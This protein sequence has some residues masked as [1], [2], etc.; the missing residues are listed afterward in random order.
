MI[1]SVQI[2]QILPHRYPFLLVDRILE[3]D[4][5]KHV[6]GLK[7]VTINEPFFQGHFPGKPIVPGVI[8]L[9]IMSQIGGFV[10]LP[11]EN[12]PPQY[13]AG[14]VVGF[15]RVRFRRF[16]V[17]GDTL[18]VEAELLGRLQSL[19]KVRATAFVKD[20]VVAKAEISYNLE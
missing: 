1:E 6:R 2:A 4:P 5:G 15:D 17:P 18:V 8:I 20:E 11:T 13:T 19:T 10:F 9:E 3:V 14:Y 7:N 16:V 12:L